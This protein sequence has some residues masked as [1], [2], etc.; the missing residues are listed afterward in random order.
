MKIRKTKIL[1]TG[2]VLA[3]LSGMTTTL[4][5]VL[6]T[7]A[8]IVGLKAPI[9]PYALHYPDSFMEGSMTGGVI[10]L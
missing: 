4:S 7:C 8:A 9:A 5:G 2:G 10:V 1:I 6:L 3:F